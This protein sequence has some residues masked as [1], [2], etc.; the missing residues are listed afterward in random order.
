MS[1][2]QWSSGHPEDDGSD[3][4]DDANN[5]D[6]DDDGYDLI[7]CARKNARPQRRLKA[8]LRTNKGS[9]SAV[10]CSCEDSVGAEMK[11]E[12]PDRPYRAV[13]R[14]PLPTET[15][16]ARRKRKQTRTRS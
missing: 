14:R 7:Q 8:S 3:D 13:C 6:D 11:C 9:D 2:L 15:L 4:N 5:P 16:P 1:M 10:A 12:S